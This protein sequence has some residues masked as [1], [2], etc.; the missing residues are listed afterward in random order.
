MSQ[1]RNKHSTAQVLRSRPQDLHNSD[2]DSIERA[3]QK[4]ESLFPPNKHHLHLAFSM[5]GIL[6]PEKSPAQLNHAQ[7][8]E[9]FAVNTIGPLLLSK[10]FT[11]FLPKKSTK[12]SQWQSTES[13]VLPNQAVWLN[14]AAR[15]GSTSDNSLGGWYSYRASK[16]GV[17][18]ITKTLDLYLKT[19]SGDNAVAIAYH[20]GTV[21]TGLSKEFWGNVKEG[22][23][24]SVEDAVDKMLKV[25]REVGVEGRGKCWDWKGE[26]IKP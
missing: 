11:P 19:R 26:E 15:V 8:K 2:E 12:L 3:A 5:P 4:A 24:F 18:S 9:T 10:H 23:L 6:Y 14:M 1:V 25:V 16:A 21:K 17:Y 22:K 20:P 7:I 13:E